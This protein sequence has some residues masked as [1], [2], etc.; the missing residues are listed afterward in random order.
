MHV[1]VGVQI[2]LPINNINKNFI[3]NILCCLAVLDDFN[4]S[5]KSI[6]NFFKVQK[7]LKGRGKIRKVKRFG[8]TFYLIDE[9]YN[10]NPLSVKTA[11]ENF[12][13]I[14]KNGTL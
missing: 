9:S 13:N 12:S 4:L 8:K 6:K 11:I 3:M 5:T 10:A 14:Q 2:S 7:P 1:F